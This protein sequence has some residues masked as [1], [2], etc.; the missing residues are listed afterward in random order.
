MTQT[1]ELAMTTHQKKPMKK[2]LMTTHQEK[3][4]KKLFLLFI[5][6]AFVCTSSFAQERR[7]G[8]QPRGDRKESAQKNQ[9][10]A[11]KYGAGEIKITDPADWI[12]N[13]ENP[14]FSGPQPGEKVPTFKASNLRGDDAGTELDP[15]SLAEGKFHI[16]FFVNKS[17]TFGR[18]LGQ[19]RKQLQSIEENSK[20]PWAMSVTVCTDDAN[21]AEKSFSVLDQRYPKNIVVG[22]SK[23]GSAGPPAYGLDRNLTATVI[24]AKNGRVAHNF[25]Y[26]GGAFY[27]QPHILGAI[28]EAMEVDHETLRKWISETPGDAAAAARS[29][30]GTRG[31]SDGSAATP[32]SGFRKLLAPLVQSGTITRAEAG[33][34]ARSSGDATAFRTKIG[35]LMKAG[36]LTRK[37][38]GEL[39]SG[40]FPENVGRR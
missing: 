10:N 23:D 2:L 19:L 35:E 20:Q 29:R 30:R 27:T 11:Y 16:M 18:F 36:K 33:E 32:K 25:P 24:V 38:V 8:E 1:P 22:L 5:A 7:G 4:M 37:Q 17:R 39:Y 14:I 9:R 40:A 21:E 3:P 26:A 28:A 13:L 15:V 34:L 6:T 12:K 31:N